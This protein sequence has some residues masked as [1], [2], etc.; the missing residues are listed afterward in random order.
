[1]EK[2]KQLQRSLPWIILV[3][4]LFLVC[5]RMEDALADTTDKGEITVHVKTEE[6]SGSDC[7]ASSAVPLS[8]C[9]MYQFI[10]FIED[11]RKIEIEVLL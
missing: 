2:K 8:S 11:G 6:L 9:E 7:G 1:M 5:F 4:V 3:V 10:N